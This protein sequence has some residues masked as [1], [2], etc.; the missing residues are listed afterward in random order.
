M[1]FSDLRVQTIVQGLLAEL[2]PGI[3]VSWMRTGEAVTLF[4]DNFDN[5]AASQLFS[6]LPG[7][8]DT[9]DEALVSAVIDQ[10]RGG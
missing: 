9:T 1:T 5:A 7:M 2:E 6:L 10:L 3:Y 8:A 4:I